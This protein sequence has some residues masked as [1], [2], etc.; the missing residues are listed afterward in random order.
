MLPSPQTFS[1]DHNASANVTLYNFQSLPLAPHTLTISLVSLNDAPTTIYF[2]YASV[3]T[4]A[5]APDS[6][7]TVSSSSPVSPSP[8]SSLSDIPSPP[9]VS[10]SP[11]QS[12]SFHSHF[13]IGAVVGSLAGL[14]VIGII[15]ALLYLW[16]RRRRH[17]PVLS[18]I[19]P[20]LHHDS[21]YQS[22]SAPTQT[23]AYTPFVS[24]LDVTS[25]LY[26]NRPS[27]SMPEQHNTITRITS[28]SIA[29]SLTSPVP[30]TS[31]A[32]STELY[33]S[34]SST[35]KSPDD[36]VTSTQVPA[37]LSGSSGRNQLTD[38]QADFVNSLY[39]HDVPAPAIARIVQRMMAGQEIDDVSTVADSHD[40]RHGDPTAPVAPPSYS[41]S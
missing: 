36:D 17:M 38:A 40:V 39:T 20:D 18:E 33:Q 25:P 15:L 34:I 32:D 5:P 6:S 22:S 30:P 16:R 3:N 12:T 35:K 41:E 19:D 2:D 37:S 27:N 31:T 4:T 29:D 23:M 8:V 24:P 7:P 21:E 26:P 11:T 14:A 13:P 9:A 1:Q 10:S 28:P